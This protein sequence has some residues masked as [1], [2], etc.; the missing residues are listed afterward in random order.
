[1]SFIVGVARMAHWF[2][3]PFL[4]VWMTV[5]PSDMLPTCLSDAKAY[6]AEQYRGSYFGTEHPKDG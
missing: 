5:A 1:M 2:L 3:I 4:V 6:I